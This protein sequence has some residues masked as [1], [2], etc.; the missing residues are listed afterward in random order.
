MGSFTINDIP[1]EDLAEENTLPETY[2]YRKATQ[3][4][5]ML[6]DTST[7]DTPVQNEFLTH[8]GKKIFSYPT[9]KDYIYKR[10]LSVNNTLINTK[11]T[12]NNNS[13]L[14]IST[15]GY[16]PVP[17]KRGGY[18]IIKSAGDWNTVLAATET[19]IVDGPDLEQPI[20]YST[21]SFYLIIMGAG[22]YGGSNKTT[23]IGSGWSGAGGGQGA[24]YMCCIS[25]P[26]EYR[27]TVV[28]IR[29]DSSIIRV[30]FQGREDCYIDIQHGQNG[31]DGVSGSGGA[32]AGGQVVK[33][34]NWDSETAGWIHEL[35]VHNG[36]AGLPTKPPPAQSTNA[37]SVDAYNPE[38]ISW[39]KEIGVAGISGY[40]PGFNK[41]GPGAGGY[42]GGKGGS[43]VEENNHIYNI[44]SEAC[45]AGG[46][47]A[48]A[49]GN[50][51]LGGML[52]SAGEYRLLF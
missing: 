6:N 21:K 44:P 2:V 18:P 11:L 42:F 41:G 22:G 23:P 35:C 51:H 4:E 1:I 47:G 52:S 19:S 14:P 29:N 43:V 50:N 33:S 8:L 28:T 31:G 36:V 40:D 48:D 10:P 34:A 45:G 24:L 37:F 17:I 30:R 5:S 25:V 12:I 13:T 27:G 3:G 20:V 9:D 46:G 49:M 15:K 16:R 26:P 7:Y 32:G 38:N 39:F